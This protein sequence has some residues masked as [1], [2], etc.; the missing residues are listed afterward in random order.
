[1]I[2]S[3][4]KYREVN[5]S[6]I[7]TTISHLDFTMLANEFYDSNRR[8]QV[9]EYILDYIRSPRTFATWYMDDGGLRREK[10]RVYGAYLN[11]QC[12][13]KKKTRYFRLVLRTHKE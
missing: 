5:A 1:L 11:T 8:K 7:F 12:F 4:P 13:S 3:V 2:L 6:W 10:G 9:T